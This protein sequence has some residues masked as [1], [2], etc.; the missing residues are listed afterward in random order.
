MIEFIKKNGKISFILLSITLFAFLLRIIGLDKESGF[1]FDEVITH[2]AATQ[3]FPSGIMK[4]TIHAPLYFLFLN[5]WMSIFSDADTTLRLFSVLLGI[6]TV[7]VMY[8]AGSELEKTEKKE[9]PLNFSKIGIL[10]ALF[11]AINSIFIYYSQELRFYSLVVLISA[12]SAYGLIR[13]IRK[14]DTLS[15]ILFTGINILLISSYVLGIVFVAIEALLLL[16]YFGINDKSGFK[17]FLKYTAGL[18]IF[19]LIIFFS[20][21]FSFINVNKYTD[22]YFIRVFDSFY[23]NADVFFILLQNWFSPF[24][25]GIHNNPQMYLSR[26]FSNGII[27]QIVIFVIIPVCIALTGILTGVFRNIRKFNI[28]KI[29]FL[30]SIFFIF[31]EI[32]L[33]Q[34]G[35]FVII[36]RYTLIILP[37]LILVMSY[38]FYSIKNILLRRS[39][40]FLFIGINLFFILLSPVS[41]PRL[42]RPEGQKHLAGVLKNIHGELGFSAEDIFIL[43][44]VGYYTDKHYKIEGKRLTFPA[45][46]LKKQNLNLYIG[47]ELEKKVTKDNAYNLLKDYLKSDLPPENLENFMKE[48]YIESLKPGRYLVLVN[49]RNL[50]IFDD[51]KLQIITRFE[52]VYKTQSLRFML[53]SKIT[54]DL[55]EIAEKHLDLT[56]EEEAD[57]WQVWVFKKEGSQQ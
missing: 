31:M 15:Y 2:W 42:Q 3:D 4:S 7:P 55:K 26:L 43:P 49:N 41:A 39:V 33:M 30:T 40:L 35:K 44:R 12:L 17:K 11:T 56:A 51:E 47:E 52:D 37:F 28:V 29:L 54:E 32:A 50:S 6:L 9:T 25:T 36:T 53:Y 22:N 19:S 24:L 23:F 45:V 1:W 16:L 13:L 18:A 20:V 8:F 14:N 21:L 48:N 10:A 46:F 27:P 38:G 34:L 57:S 5:L